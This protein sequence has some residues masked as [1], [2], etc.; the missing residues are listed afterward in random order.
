MHATCLRDVLVLAACLGP[1]S[2][3]LA[4]MPDA[5]AA[6]AVYAADE[7]RADDPHEHQPVEID[8]RPMVTRLDVPLLRPRRLLVESDGRIVVADWAAGT[9]I[10]VDPEGRHSLLATGLY[11]PAGLARDPFGVVY[12][13]THAGG[14]TGAGGIHRLMPGD[15][16]QPIV[17]GLTGPTD[18]AFGPDGYLY[19]ASFHEDAI[20]RVG[21]DGGM[22]MIVATVPAPAALAFDPAGVLHVASSTDGALFRISSMGEV[23]IVARDLHVPS[24]LAFDREGHLIVANYGTKELT[25]VEPF[26]RLQK[27]AIVPEGTIA[28]DFD[29]DGNLLFVNWDGQYLMKVTT[30]LTVPCPHCGQPIPVRL[31]EVQPPAESQPAESAPAESP[32]LS[33]PVI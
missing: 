21:P 18:L 5:A 7:L 3:V 6:G 13:S 26:G 29:A 24:D 33:R 12:V 32:M 10:E 17:D 30:K 20:L 27:F 25:Y 8:S 31:R 4:Q 11:E 15:E 1:V 14:M 2:A 9:V 16:P 28:I 22:A 23:T 19:V